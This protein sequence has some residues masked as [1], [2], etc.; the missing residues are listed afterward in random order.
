MGLLASL[1]AATLIPVTASQS[2]I[3]TNP[4][5]AGDG[6]NR[7]AVWEEGARVLAN[8][9]GPDNTPFG[10]NAILISSPGVE[11]HS[12]AIAALPGLF[13][14]VWIEN[15]TVVGGLYTRNLERFARIDLAQHAE[16]FYNPPRIALDQDEWIVAYIGTE[17][18]RFTTNAV[19]VGVNGVPLDSEV[20]DGANDFSVTTSS[21]DVTW[22]GSRPVF[23]W[24]RTT[25]NNGI[26]PRQSIAVGD[27]TEM[28]LI[29]SAGPGIE[30]R[31]RIAASLD[32]LSVLVTWLRG[33]DLIARF[34]PDLSGAPPPVSGRRHRAVAKPEP[35]LL[36]N[37]ERYT[38]QWNANA[39]EIVWQPRGDASIM[40]TTLDEFG[41]G[42][43]TSL[44]AHVDDPAALLEDSI[45][46]ATL[47]VSSN[48]RLFWLIP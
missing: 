21:A 46:P 30:N 20:I 32:R 13:F 43:S 8:G 48:G 35:P 23:A 36:T 22:R 34:N 44:L 28:N 2:A 27:V 10:P 11:A 19:R 6:I 39:F 5:I 33:T 18:T 4:R 1:L 47:V 40:R 24:V 9:L 31:P 29:E 41:T 3:Q 12:P 15:T 42:F 25:T 38:L 14:I 45:D 16:P 37:V 17:G 26:P 7:V